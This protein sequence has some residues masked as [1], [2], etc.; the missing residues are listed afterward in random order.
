MWLSKQ[1]KQPAR[2]NEGQTGVVTLSGNGLT[3]R[4][5]SEV[6]EPEIYGPAGYGWRPKAGDRVL[7]IK[8]EGEHPCVVGTGKGTVPPEVTLTADMIRLQGQ[9]TVNGIALEDYIRALAKEVLGG[10]M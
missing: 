8:G 6:S 7:V 1:Q 9:V 5:D 2:R 10:T 4:L 3:V